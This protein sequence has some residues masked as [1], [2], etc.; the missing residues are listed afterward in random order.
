MN[1]EAKSVIEKVGVLFQKSGF[2]LAMG[3]VVA[4]LM[5]AEPPQKTFV[6]IQNDLKLSK[7]AVSNTLN[8][9]MA[10]NLV[11]Y[12]TQTGDRKRYFCFNADGWL[13]SQRKKI[14]SN[15]FGEMITSVLSVRSDKYLEQ[16]QKLKEIQKFN[17]F[18]DKEISALF[19]KWD[20][21]SGK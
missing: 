20:R 16:N 17:D 19:E 8:M 2:P 14:Q 5:V 10:F 4:Y 7:S 11:D 9:L 21:Q 3:R 15:F 18:L 13:A 12:I 6:E 1:K